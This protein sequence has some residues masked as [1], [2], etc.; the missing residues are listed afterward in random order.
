[1]TIIAWKF[2]DNF[3]IFFF[4]IEHRFLLGLNSFKVIMSNEEYYVAF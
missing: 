2:F 1:M 3:L 4:T